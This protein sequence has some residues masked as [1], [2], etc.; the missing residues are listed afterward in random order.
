MANRQVGVALYPLHLQWA[1][2]PQDAKVGGLQPRAAGREGISAF[3][4]ID[5][6]IK[7]KEYNIQ[8]QL[9]GPTGICGSWPCIY[10]VGTSVTQ[11]E[12]G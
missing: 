12:E 10:V 3:A 7:K 11:D 4:R 1:G 2:G 9:M 6:K 5:A 8:Q